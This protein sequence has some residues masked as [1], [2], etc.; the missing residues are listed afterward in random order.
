MPSNKL[1]TRDAYFGE[2][3]V[4]TKGIQ[5]LFTNLKTCPLSRVYTVSAAVLVMNHTKESLC[6]LK[7]IVTQLLKINIA[8]K[9]VAKKNQ[10][11]DSLNKSL[12]KH[13]LNSR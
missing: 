12:L 10:K 13:L 2:F 8:T 4:D 9:I 3:Q 7:S 11:E 5:A 1:P 6:P